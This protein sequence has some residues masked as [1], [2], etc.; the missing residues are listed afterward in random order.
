MNEHFEYEWDRVREL[1]VF[2]TF[3]LLI[4]KIIPIF[5]MDADRRAPNVYI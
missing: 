3:Y 5:V 4:I 1:L 2:Y